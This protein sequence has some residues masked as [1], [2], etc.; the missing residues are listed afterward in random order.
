MEALAHQIL[1]RWPLAIADVQMAAQRENAVFRVTAGDGQVFALRLHRPGYRSIAELQSELQWM[2]AVARGGVSIPRPLPSRRGALVE[3]A[4]DHAADLLTWLP[5]QPMGKTGTPLN[6][7]EAPQVFFT[8]GQAM[9]RLHDVSDAWI[10]P[11][12]FTRHAWD[13]EGLLGEAPVW[14]RFWE[15]PGLGEQQRRLIVAARKKAR[16]VLSSL[17]GELDYGLIHSDLVRENVLIDGRQLH[18]IDFDDGG[19][20]YRLFDVATALLKNRNEPDYAA[21]KTGLI[22]GYRSVRPLDTSLL[23]LFLMLRAF[24]YLGWIV[25]RMG[26]AGGE[27]RNARFI[28]ESTGLAEAWLG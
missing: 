18:F 27:A 21:L 16:A 8:L 12:G 14:G 2:A 10:A 24:T 17:A 20:G 7:P 15:N 23:P 26:E 5:G 1:E 19:F 25:P 4:G 22:T 6:L 9:A 3:S 11:T 28:A 13:I